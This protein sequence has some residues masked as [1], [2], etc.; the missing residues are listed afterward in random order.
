MCNRREN[1]NTREAR[2]YQFTRNVFKH[3]RKSTVLKILDGTFVMDNK[4]LESSDIQE[5]EDL[6][7]SRL[8][9]GNTKDASSQKLED[10]I[11]RQYYGVITPEEVKLCVSKFKWD[12]SPGRDL[13]A[14]S[15]LKL[16]TFDDIAAILNKWWGNNISDSAKECRTTLIPKTVD[17][18]KNPSDWHPITIGNLFIQLYT[19]I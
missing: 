9:K 17:D 13:V 6:Y 5:I 12:I 15:D 3:N 1:R 19:K 14:L 10:T 4:G 8:E 11:N 16:L 2:N 7:V 18:L